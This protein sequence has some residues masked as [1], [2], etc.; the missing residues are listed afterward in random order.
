M[1]VSEWHSSPRVTALV[2]WVL[3]LI[4]S[5]RKISHLS[6]CTCCSGLRGPMMESLSLH[7]QPASTH[8]KTFTSHLF[9]LSVSPP[10]CFAPDWSASSLGFFT[11]SNCSGAFT[12]G[13][14]LVNWYVTLRRN[15]ITNGSEANR[16][17]WRG[18][19]VRSA[20]IWYK[21]ET[22]NLDVSLHSCVSLFFY[23]PSIYLLK[24]KSL[25]RLLVNMSNLWS[26]WPICFKYFSVW[27]L[28]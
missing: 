22:S 7:S 2:V 24:R 14:L 19:T 11:S 27:F 20:H 16:F 4:T 21:S 1:C 9:S 18:S 23:E 6:Q 25:I 8:H 5:V 26:L 10:P 17:V 3:S 28:L 15:H 13:V 12:A